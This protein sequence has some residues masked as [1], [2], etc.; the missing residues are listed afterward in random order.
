MILLPSLIYLSMESFW[1]F[2]EFLECLVPLDYGAVQNTQKPPKQVPCVQSRANNMQSKPPCVLQMSF[3]SHNKSRSLWNTHDLAFF[4]KPHNGNDKTKVNYTVYGLGQ[5]TVRFP[6]DQKVQFE[7]RDISSGEWN[8]ISE[9][10]EKR[11][12]S[13]RIPKFSKNFSSGISVK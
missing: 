12:A 7:F 3:W 13:R 8:S 11:S 9:I 10:S 4:R 5:E 6:F 1:R 2:L